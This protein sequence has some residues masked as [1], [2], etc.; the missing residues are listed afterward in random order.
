MKLLDQTYT[1][2]RDNMFWLTNENFFYVIIYVFIYLL[3]LFHLFH[4]FADRSQSPNS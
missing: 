3:L 4:F 1:I 2:I